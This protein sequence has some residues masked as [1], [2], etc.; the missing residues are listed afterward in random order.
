MKFDFKTFLRK[1]KEHE[2]KR[3]FDLNELA[4]NFLQGLLLL[5]PVVVTVYVVFLILEAMDS[6]LRLPIPGLGFPIPGL[7]ILVTV[8][9]IIL[10][11]RLAS[12]VFVQGA[13]KSM[14]T[15]LTRT[16]FVKL[17]YTS[18]KDLIE[19]FMGEK[20]RFDQPVLVTLAA[21][22]QAQAIGFVTRQSLDFLGVYDRVAVYFPQSYNF[23]GNLL[24]FPRSQ[25]QPLEVDS[26]E[27][28][29]FIVSGGVSG[30]ITGGA[31]GVPEAEARA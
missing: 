22:S 3:K 19:A 9:M 10:V 6:W 26:A 23:A 17:L 2:L 31:S 27:L 16:P 1:V 21:G 4:K 11:G 29:A 24:V 28:M 7:G 13:L 8:G 15:L 5:V 14:D 30:G 20:K 25:V 12:N 18:L